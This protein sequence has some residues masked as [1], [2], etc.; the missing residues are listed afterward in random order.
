MIRLTRH[1]IKRARQRLGIP[2][3]AVSRVVAQAWEGG[4]GLAVLSGQRELFL[5]GTTPSDRTIRVFRGAVFVFGPGP[6]FVTVLPGDCSTEH[7]AAAHSLLR[8]EAAASQRSSRR[9][10]QVRRL[11]ERQQARWSHHA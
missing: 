3:R 7:C 8:R 2:A 11:R 1:G 4:A 9:A 6:V 5:R 10:K